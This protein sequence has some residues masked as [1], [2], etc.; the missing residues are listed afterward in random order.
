VSLSGGGDFVDNFLE[1]PLGGVEI[2]AVEDG[3][4]G[5]GD[6]GPLVEPG[7]VGL[8]VLLE[9]ELAA[10][11]GDTSETGFD[12]SAQTLVIVADD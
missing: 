12:G 8:G 4:N 9:V 3:S 2:G 1:T 10:L 6:G 5:V 7:H 11:V